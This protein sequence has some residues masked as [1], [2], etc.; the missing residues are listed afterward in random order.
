VARARLCAGIMGVAAI[1][2][3]LAGCRQTASLSVQEVVVV[4]KPD[5]TQADHARVYAACKAVPGVS[6]EPL[7]T[8]SKY[9]ATLQNNVRYRVDHASNAELQQLYSC[10]AKDPSVAGYKPPVDIGQ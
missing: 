10:L 2:A 8:D 9:L 5:A 7:V 3:S 1:A 4:F 6:P